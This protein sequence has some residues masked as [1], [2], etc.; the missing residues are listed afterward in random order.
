[1]GEVI[2]REA[3]EKDL[4][5]VTRLVV[6]LKRLNEE[7]DPLLKNVQ[8]IEEACREYMKKA[9]ESRDSLVIV[10]EHEG[11]VVGVLKAGFIDRVFYDPPL[12]GQIQEFYLL[13]QY[14]RMGIGKKMLEYAM[15]KLKDRVSFI[16]VSFPS[17]NTIAVSFYQKFGFRPIFSVYA[18]ETKPAP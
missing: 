5:Q 15:E 1:M 17:L 10:A 13:P 3:V 18:K 16:T 11:R 2:L 7:F 14:R 9:I 12:E 8:N 4:D 6:R